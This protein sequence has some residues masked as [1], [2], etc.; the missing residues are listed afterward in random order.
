MLKIGDYWAQI[1]RSGKPSQADLKNRTGVG[2]NQKAKS[3]TTMKPL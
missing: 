2:H 1:Y 3:E